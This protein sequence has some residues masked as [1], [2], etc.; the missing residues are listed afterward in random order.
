MSA[1]VQLE[2]SVHAPDRY[3]LTVW[4]YRSD[5]DISVVVRDHASRS[6]DQV[7]EILKGVLPA[8]LGQLSGE[9]VI[10]EFVLPLELL[11]E[12]VHL[13]QVFRHSYARLGYRYPVVLR[14]LDRFTDEE[15]RQH[16]CPRWDFLSTCDGMSLYWLGCED[17]R[18]SE[19]LYR[20]FESSP[21]YAA[22]GMPGPASQDP[23]RSA[24]DAAMYAGVPVALWRLARCEDHDGATRVGE[25]CDGIRFHLVADDTMSRT[26]LNRL[27]TM[28]KALRTSGAWSECAL[29]WDNPYRGPHPR[30]LV[31]P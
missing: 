21:Q 23:G 30:R 5:T 13:W 29:L 7:V 8:T 10:V 3:L 27:P 28:I 25:P 14:D 19:D 26:P 18:R 24:L 11:D 31:E 12:P 1:V 16:S 9:P 22:F 6:R 4:R 15:S 2:P 17:L 20:L